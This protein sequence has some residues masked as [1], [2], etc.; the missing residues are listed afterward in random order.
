METTGNPG[1]DSGHAVAQAVGYAMSF[2]LRRLP[3]VDG[4]PRGVFS[5]ELPS[6]H[7]IIATFLILYW[8]PALSTLV[9]A[10]QSPFYESFILVCINRGWLS[11]AHLILQKEIIN[12]HQNLTLYTDLEK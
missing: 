4:S 6:L 9:Y 12:F 2:H 5:A 11:R 1:C 8:L 3:S 10:C 7:S